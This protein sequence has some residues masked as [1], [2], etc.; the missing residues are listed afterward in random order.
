[1]NAQNTQE[2]APEWFLTK[3][4][5][6]VVIGAG[7]VGST[8]AMNLDGRGFE[9]LAC[10]HRTRAAADAAREATKLP[11]VAEL[12]PDLISEADIV[13]LSVP[14][15]AIY[16]ITLECLEKKLFRPN[17]FL[18]HVSGLYSS[19]ILMEAKRQV[20]FIG[21]LHPIH[22]FSSRPN[23][24]EYLKVGTRF[25][26]EGDPEARHLM[27]RMI[28]A[29]GGIPYKIASSDKVLYNIAGNV[30]SNF[31]V[32]VLHMAEEIY[33]EIG[34]PKSVAQDCYIPLLEQVLLS[35]RNNGVGRSLNGPVAQGKLSV[36]EE[37]LEQLERRLME[38]V[39]LYKKLTERALDIAYETGVPEEV[40]K[41]ILEK[42]QS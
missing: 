26:I 30:V 15:E 24:M 31:T 16:D 34:M 32:A 20:S 33:D 36:V 14:D 1:M 28:R 41:P 17:Q 18:L 4:M 39:D 10:T 7:R 40:L 12:T 25:V 22:G 27:R 23:A 35:V 42:V 8:L 38:N 29:V 9:I 2:T 21:S 5:K 37:H 3:T 19:D 11:Q 13:L 6:I